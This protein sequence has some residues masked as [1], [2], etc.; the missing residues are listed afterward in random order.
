MSATFHPR[1]LNGFRNYARAAGVGVVLIAA[2]ALTGW[3]FDI[4]PLRSLVPGFTAMNPGG[5]AIA[6]LLAG[7]GLLVADNRRIRTAC[8]G[9]VLGIAVLRLVGY[10]F[11]WDGGP[12]QWLFRAKLDME[13][14]GI[15][16]V[17]R[18]APNTAWS[19]L[20]AGL[21]L[22]VL[23]L[24][25]GRGFWPAQLLALA[26]A[27]VA[28]LTAVGYSYS[29]LTL[30]GDDRNIPMA[31]NTAIAFLL[32][33]T[34]TL[35]ARPDRGI[36][37]VFSSAGPGGMMARRLLPA[38]IAIPAAVGWGVWLGEQSRLAEPVTALSVLVVANIV[39]FAALIWANA[40]SL[41]KAERRR[42]RTEQRLVAQH[43]ATRV[44]AESPRADDAI[45]AI[46]Q[47]IVDSLQCA[48]GAMWR[49]DRQI[50]MLRC[51]NICHD[52]GDRIADFVAQCHN[53]TFPRGIGLPGRVWA[54][55]KSTWIP[56]V[57]PD[58]NF[59]RA[60]TANH[61]GLH[62]AVG[63]P[64]AVG[65]DIF[66]VMEFFARA[67]E[68]PDEELQQMLASIGGQIGQFLMR[69]HAEEE[70]SLERHL[71]HSLLDAIPDSVFFKDEASRFLRTSRALTARLGLADPALAL[72]KTDFDFFAEEHARP[73]AEDEKEV[74]R[75]GQPMVNKEEKETWTDGQERWVVTSKLPL[76]DPAGRIVGTFGISRDVTEHKL[77]EEA[78][79]ESE[80]RYALAVRGTNDGL[81][82]WDINAHRVY[83]S[84]RFEELLGYAPGEFGTTVT[85]FPDHTHPDDSPTARA[86]IVDHLKQRVPYDIEFRLRT[87]LGE[88]RWFHARGQAVWGNDGRA[89]RMAGSINDVTARKQAEAELLHAKEAAES[90]TRTKSEFLANMSHEI[91][92]P[93]NGILGMTELALDSDLAPDQREYLSLA[94][95]SAEHLLTVVNDI[96]DFSKIEAGKLD[97]EATDFSLRNLLDDTVATLATRAHA[98]GLELADH[99]ATDVPDALAGDPHR[100]RQIIV[101]LIGNA[102]KFTDRGEVVLRVESHEPAGDG[103][104]LHFSVHD[105]GIGISPGQCAKLFQAFTQA[106]TSTTRKYG[107]TGLGLAIASR[108][109]EMMGGR[110]WL[111]SE[112]GRGSTFHFTAT[113]QQAEKPIVRPA[114]ADPD[115]VCGLPVLVVDD[116][117]TNR[118]VLQEMIGNWGMRPTVVEGGRAALAELERARDSGEPY[119]L[120]L[121]DAMMPEMDGFDLAERIRQLPGAVGATL[122]MLS[123]AD[124]REDATRCGN[125]GVA[126]YLTK[127]VRQSTLLDAIMVALGGPGSEPVDVE[128][129]PPRPERGRRLRL[130]L[131]DDNPVNQKLAV[132]LLKKRGHAVVV[133][134]TGR[135]ALAALDAG[136]FD[137]VLM[138]VQMPEMDGLE[139]T[140]AIRARERGTGEHVPI[141]AMT[142]HAMQ[143]DRERCLDAGMDAYVSKPI[144]A[145]ALFATLHDLLSTEGEVPAVASDGAAP[146]AE[147]SAV[148][149]V[150]EAVGRLG[151]DRELFVELA[152]T[153]LGQLPTWV[154]AIRGAVARGDAK[155]L[156]AA[157]H[158]LKGSLGTFAAKPAAE[159]AARLE[160]MGRAGDLSNAPV[161]LDCLERELARLTPALSELAAVRI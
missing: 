47:A 146:R 9:G 19:F 56:D 154:S 86:A 35:A 30:A 26:F 75:T 81:W 119:A 95:S 89:T 43:T 13:A 66:G 77:A 8:A 61:A 133:A 98:K 93:L 117:A 109:V 124:R 114:P 5:T 16:P 74:M 3:A 72:G 102:I 91:R 122:M 60:A 145:D 78:L 87:K 49:V 101:N 28:L 40:A 126:S 130:L 37:T 32:V 22:L 106:D 44:L 158:P 54:S 21:A 42:K 104:G 76:R 103:I 134:G 80:E 64:I 65:G 155:Q 151:G 118:L 149:D 100:L 121:L 85:A 82:D 33:G 116:N 112:V 17:N 25:I 142:A 34:G 97:L 137:A 83:F 36:M 58:S 141:V 50:G 153:F 88:Y 99:V 147:A 115:A 14:A 131:A 31:L 48:V 139:A 7:I 51:T 135:E 29:A 156:S 57:V 105:T 132:S 140:A 55:G 24:R 129:P 4:V 111:E 2:L 96:L 53:T 23:D 62:A 6:F 92:T 73:A 160:A 150:D 41:D 161:A 59:P 11:G 94:K 18:M 63:F 107:G 113:F 52:N 143:G 71:L 70:L 127:P 157:A 27:L 138:D 1:I 68:E 46:L 12:D 120:V 159:A 144:R 148:L 10:A 110:V 125:L 90:A 15:G 67:I 128:I 20:A 152:A 84:T 69:K 136:T 39:L 123:S 45:P 38:A 79:R 108:L